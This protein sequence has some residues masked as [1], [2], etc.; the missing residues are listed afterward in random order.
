MRKLR[1]LCL[2]LL[3]ASADVAA[4]PENVDHGYQSCAACHVSPAGGG[5]LTPYGR[6]A[7]DAFMSTWSPSET[8]SEPF[9]GAGHDVVPEWFRLGG[10]QRAV[11]LS[12]LDG[13]KTRMIPMQN[14][15]ELAVSP[16]N[17]PGLTL[18]AEVGIYGPQHDVQY[19]RAF[20]RLDLS[21]AVG[22]RLGHFVPSYGLNLPDHTTPTRA[23]MGLG[24]GSETYNAEAFWLA[25][26]G[27]LEATAVFGSDLEVD[28]NRREPGAYRTDQ[29]TGYSIRG[30]LYTSGTSQVGLSLMQVSSFD[31]ARTAFGGFGS[32]GLAERVWFLAEVDQ[33]HDQEADGDAKISTV[34]TAKV[35][36]RVYPGVTFTLQ[37][38]TVDTAPD[39]RAGVQWMPV[40]HI[41][42]TA[43]LRRTW[44]ASYRAPQNSGL[45][46]VHHWL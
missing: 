29:A 25:S 24:E 15:F 44:R 18:D 27:E 7:A 43:E 33:R 40:P 1:F 37:G 46:L 6:G 39:A 12:S 23:A 45:L 42:M 8:F 34:A 31:A 19:R 30:A 9:Y 5:T 17:N 21:P 38:D 3:G 13:S 10:D 32:I 26:R 36:W 22:I 28:L 14:D 4:F 2:A 11:Y 41:E 20:L 16:P 35:G